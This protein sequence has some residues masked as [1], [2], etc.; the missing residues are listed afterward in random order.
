M[1]L[2]FSLEFLDAKFLN[3]SSYKIFNQHKICVPMIYN[4]SIFVNFHFVLHQSPKS[5]VG[6]LFNPIKYTPDTMEKL[7]TG[8]FFDQLWPKV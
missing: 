5:T 1:L 7:G 8:R 6:H 4:M 2:Y 3:I